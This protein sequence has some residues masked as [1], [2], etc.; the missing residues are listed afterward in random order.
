V[1]EKTEE[2]SKAQISTINALAILSESRDRETGEHI[3]RV[4]ILCYKLASRLPLSYFKNQEEKEYFCSTI[5]LASA[6]HDIGKVGIE[7]AILNKPGSL[8]YEEMERM[9]KHTTIGSETLE[10]L[11]K[12]Y[13]NNYFVK[14]GNEITRY[15]HEHWNGKGYP[16]GLSGLSIPLSARIMAIVDV[17]DA[18]IS[19]R[20]YKE[21]FT[22]ELAMRIIIQ[23][24]GSHFDPDLVKYFCEICK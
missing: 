13:P 12:Q 16:D 20:P 11:L 9:K 10:K 1:K 5:R 18:L 3:E 22:H 15:H 24:A 19:K 2:I 21:A 14:L 17:Y 4:G 6:L 23:D 7:D 8:S